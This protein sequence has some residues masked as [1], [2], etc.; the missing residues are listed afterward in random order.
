M[1]QRATVAVDDQ[2]VSCCTPLVG[3]ALSE[4]EATDL[5]QIFGA[6]GDPVRLRMLSMIASQ[7]E[8][9]S[10]ALEDPLGKSQ[11]TVSHHTKI[12]AAAG[13]ITGERRGRWVWWRVNLERLGDMARI[14]SR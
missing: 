8:I 10:C 11:P 14:L 13:L 9:C 4:I 3:A 1:A 7:D 6:L 2:V 5:A 12:L